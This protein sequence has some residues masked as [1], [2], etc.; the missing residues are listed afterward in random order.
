MERD[1][2]RSRGQ[3]RGCHTFQDIVCDGDQSFISPKRTGGLRM[4]QTYYYYY[5]IDGSTETHDPAMPST[6]SC[7]YLPGQTVNTL[8]V[9]TEHPSRHRSASM[10]S[11]TAADYRTMNPMDKFRSPRPAP[12]APGMARSLVSSSPS[13]ALQLHKPSPPEVPQ[14]QRPSRS[15]SP[16]PRWV[17]ARRLFGLKPSKRGGS[18]DRSKGAAPANSCSDNED[19]ASMKS[20]HSSRSTQSFPSS[21]S[22][23]AAEHP[24]TRSTTPSGGSS[25]SR[26]M[27]PEALRRFLCDDKP[28]V[29][30]DPNPAGGGGLS[31]PEQIM[32]ENEDDDNF[33]SHAAAAG[34]GEGAPST[35]LSPPPFLRSFSSPSI[36]SCVN[37]SSDT[38]V[39]NHPASAAR[40]DTRSEQHSSTTAAGR[41]SAA[42]KLHIPK[43]RFSLSS[44]SS[45][46]AGAYAITTPFSPT[47][48][49]SSLSRSSRGG[50]GSG[51]SSSYFEGEGDHDESEETEEEDDLRPSRDDEKLGGGKELYHPF[52]GY[53]LPPQ[54]P[55]QKHHHNRD[56]SALSQATVTAESPQFLARCD[57]GLPV[58][59]N[60]TLLNLP[61]IDAGLDDLSSDAG[62]MA[63]II[64][65]RES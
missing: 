25:R 14:P 20:C 61:T 62:W 29:V 5:E 40:P 37:A 51:S 4:G 6:T 65:P 63:D 9:P 18:C 53:S 10:T 54:E 57:N 33:A 41:H 49:I 39:P 12:T 7:P 22:A 26:D 60:A 38:I 32:E 27:S 59:D 23:S 28:P 42:F 43:S 35:L 47:S 31:I 45:A 58:G 52:A 55:G 48:S 36:T 64:R 34:A 21:A 13:E 30:T 56:P 16:T 24:T 46:A 44:S 15:Q 2:R 50:G 3:W 1:A 8:D 17:S 19:A 11:V